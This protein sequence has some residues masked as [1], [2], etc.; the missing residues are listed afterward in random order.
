M[1]KYNELAADLPDD[2]IR[3]AESGVFGSVELEDYA[4]AGADAVLVGEGVA[5]A[6][7]HEQAVERTSKGRSKSESIRTNPAW[8]SHEGT[9]ISVSSVDAMCR[10]ALITALDELERVYEEAKLIRNF[11]RNWLD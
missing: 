2:V 5:T 4:R 7:N 11:I 1:N 3:V 8:A 10:Q 6:S 9:D